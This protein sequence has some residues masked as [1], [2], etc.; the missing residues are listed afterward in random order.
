MS[1]KLTQAI[2]LIK[3]GKRLPARDLLLEV[4]K[5][6]PDDLNAWLWALE[7]AANE[8]EKRLILRKILDIDPTHAGALSYLK[9]LDK[10]LSLTKKSPQNHQRQAEQLP[11]T[12]PSRKTSGLSGLLGL[13]IDWI[14]S[15]PSGCVYIAIFAGIVVSLFIYTRVNTSLFGLAGAEFDNLV[16]SNSYELIS[17]DELYWEVQF[18]GIGETK[19][20]GTVRYAAP[21]RIQEFA[22]LTHD[23]LVTTGDFANPDI[24][25]TNVIDHKFFWKAP[26]HT[27]PSGAINLIHALPANKTIYQQMLDIDKW[28][29]VKIT[30]R[31][32]LNIKAFQSDETFLGTWMD[33]GCNTL[34]VE[35]VTI[36]KGTDN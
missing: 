2:Q 18:E 19:F 26:N 5:A 6:N 34:L 7:V 11:G 9:K 27:A 8:K 16:I 10:K 24:V 22:I 15:L 30:G 4:V 1:E 32:I 28:D 29:T 17:S 31:E 33:T 23:I 12:A 14:T 21:I 25:N 35:S 20:I 13:I 3:E 36:I